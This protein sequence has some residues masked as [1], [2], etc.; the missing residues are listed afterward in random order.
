MLHVTD[1]TSHAMVENVSILVDKDRATVHNLETGDAYSFVLQAYRKHYDIL[2]ITPVS[3]LVN[4]TIPRPGRRK[5]NLLAANV[6]RCGW[7]Q[8]KSC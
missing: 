8:Y 5:W 6:V 7:Y 1:S 2:D 4:A 3:V